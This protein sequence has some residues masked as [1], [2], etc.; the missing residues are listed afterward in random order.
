MKST[1]SLQRLSNIEVS[2]SR[3]FGR[4]GWDSPQYP[5][6]IARFKH[7]SAAEKGKPERLAGTIGETIASTSS[8]FNIA[9]LE[10]ATLL[11][12]V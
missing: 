10:L 8:S 5:S 4:T 2:Q 9:T 3:S 11:N 7:S 12:H 1:D 6:H